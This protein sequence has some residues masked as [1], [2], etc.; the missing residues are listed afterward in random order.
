MPHAAAQPRSP[1]DLG[2]AELE[3]DAF[4]EADRAE[5]ES[6]YAAGGPGPAVSVGE[7]LDGDHDEL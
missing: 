2:E 3:V 5:Y 1:N 7:D 4:A 6:Y